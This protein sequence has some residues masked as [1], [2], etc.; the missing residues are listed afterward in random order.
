M[1]RLNFEGNLLLKHV[2]QP[3]I[4]GNSHFQACGTTPHRG[5]SLSQVYK[6]I[7][8]SNEFLLWHAEQLVLHV[9]LRLVRRVAG[10]QLSRGG[11]HALRDQLVGGAPKHESVAVVATLGRDVLEQ[12]RRAGHACKRTWISMGIRSRTAR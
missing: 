11:C 12:A 6:T 8:T 3:H 5:D 10:E 4:D 2:E 7:S 1:G 9:V